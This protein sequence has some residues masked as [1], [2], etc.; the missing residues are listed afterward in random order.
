[1]TDKKGNAT[2]PHRV[3][4][5]LWQDTHSGYRGHKLMTK[6]LADT[7]PLY[8]NDDADDPYSVAASVKL[9]SP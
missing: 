6:E 4:A 8:A 5:R 7:I 3:R 9:F 2:T 1:M